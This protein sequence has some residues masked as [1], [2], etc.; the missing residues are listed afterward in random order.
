M[1]E[2]EL[3]QMHRMEREIALRMSAAQKVEKGLR[4]DLEERRAIRRAMTPEQREQY[5]EM[6]R[7]Q[8][9]IEDQNCKRKNNGLKVRGM[10]RFSI[11]GQMYVAHT[12]AAAEKQAG[13]KNVK[14]DRQRQGAKKSWRSPIRKKRS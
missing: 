12:R 2:R 10:K 13:E 4:L 7:K 11:N 6:A 14:A 9:A 8:Q 3:K 5:D 1:T